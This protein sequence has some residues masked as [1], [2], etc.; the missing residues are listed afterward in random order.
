MKKTYWQLRRMS[1]QEL[2]DYGIKRNEID[3]HAQRIGVWYFNKP[4]ILEMLS[5]THREW[6]IN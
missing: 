4:T 3:N 1:K 2:W 5:V 6:A